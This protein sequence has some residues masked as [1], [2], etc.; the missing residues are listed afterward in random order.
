MKNQIFSVSVTFN[1]DLQLLDRQVKSLYN[2]VKCIVIVDNGSSNINEL[3]EYCL[4]KQS[5][6]FIDNGKNMGL[7]YAQ[8]IGI[9]EAFRNN[10]TD[11]LLLD[12]DSVL[13]EDFTNNLLLAREELITQDVSVGALGPIYYNEA[14]NEIYPITK[15][16]GPFIKRFAPTTRPEEASFLIA[17]GCLININVLKDVG[18]MN[19]KLF[20]DFIDVDW[21]FR[22]QAKKYKLFVVPNAVMMHTIG[23]SRMN[24]GGRSIAIHSP[25]RRYYLFRNSVFMVRNKNMPWG[26][27]LREV[28]LNTFRIIVYLSM[29]KDKIRY[30]KYSLSGLKDGINNIGGECTHKF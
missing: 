17:S 10:A 25:L 27:K 9:K 30:L 5:L 22:A 20:I 21:S 4:E 19:E 14:T 7:G 18:F 12:Q 11:V 15:F 8:N 24:V 6:I 1:P 28:V 3:K 13:K 2:Q 16:W 23:E 29:T 26:Y